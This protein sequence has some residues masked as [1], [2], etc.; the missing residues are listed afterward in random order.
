M[1][2]VHRLSAFSI[3]VRYAWSAIAF[4]VWLAIYNYYKLQ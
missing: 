3:R 2:N 4:T 1:R